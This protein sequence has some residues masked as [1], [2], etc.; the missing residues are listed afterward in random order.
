MYICTMKKLF[1]LFFYS[2]IV[3][4][5]CNYVKQ[6]TQYKSVNESGWEAKDTLTFIIPID[7]INKNYKLSLAVRHNKSYEFNNFWV[8]I[9]QRKPK[10]KI[11][12]S[13]KDIPLYNNFGKPYGKCTGSL[14]TQI[15]PIEKNIQFNKKGN[16]TIKVIHLMRQ[17]PL[18]G[19]K[20]IGIVVE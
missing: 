3:F 17:E 16:Y 8:K 9:G 19:I 13:N 20:D 6:N 18:H 5:S 14:C 2:I 4:S 7:N 12:Y 15:F 11:M 10:E 1:S